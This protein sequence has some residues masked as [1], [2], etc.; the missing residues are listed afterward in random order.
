MTDKNI[1]IDIPMPITTPRLIIRPAMP[2]DGAAMHEAK[3]E[4]YDELA[5]WMPWAKKGEAV[6]E[7]EIVVREAYARFIRRED[8]MLMGFSRINGE[9]IIASGLHR[10]DWNSR[11]FEIGYWTNKAYHNQGYATEA[12]NALTRFA[13]NVLNARRVEIRYDEGNE[14]SAR[15]PS[16]LGFIHEGVTRFADVLP[17]GGPAHVHTTA[18]YDLNNLPPLEVT[19]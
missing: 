5:K 1:L 10:F 9:F 17:T 15:V 4:T 18:R 19:W 7:S 11:R 2:G 8:L 13:F 12:A 3:I 16:K 14:N 6:E